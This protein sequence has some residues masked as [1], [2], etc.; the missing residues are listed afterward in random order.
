MKI[1]E[2]L[3]FLSGNLNDLILTNQLTLTNCCCM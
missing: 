1:L 2:I 3:P